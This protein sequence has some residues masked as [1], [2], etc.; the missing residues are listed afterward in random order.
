[1]ADQDEGVVRRAQMRQERSRSRREAMLAATLD[2]LVEGGTRAVTHRAIAEAT[3]FP[4]TTTA[5]YFGSVDELIREALA[6]RIDSW[7]QRL[8]DVLD[9]PSMEHPGAHEATRLISVAFGG[10][11][12]EGAYAGLRLFVNACADPE[13][14]TKVAAMV[15]ESER[16]VAEL[17]RR[18]GVADPERV[19]EVMALQLGGRVMRIASGRTAPDEE[20]ASI[21]ATTDLLVRA[22]RDLP[23]RPSS[24]RSDEHP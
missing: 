12:V 11:T 4:L 13:V 20:M 6:D 21:V 3:G 14:R 16:V 2:L 5:Y 8:R 1:M 22:V 17:M 23:P 10:D 24:G 15:T 7:T 9:E 19:A 18:S